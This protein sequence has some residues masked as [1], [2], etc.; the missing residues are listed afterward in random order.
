[1]V[2]LSGIDEAGVAGMRYE[3]TYANAKAD[4][5]QHRALAAEKMLG[6][7]F[8]REKLMLAA[9]STQTVDPGV[10]LAATRGDDLMEMLN[11]V[12]STESETQARVEQTLAKLDTMERRREA[13][14]ATDA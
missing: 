7:A 11:V 4:A 6:R 1:M 13:I 10:D 2:E 3:G 12:L 9:L 14:T 5:W 8:E